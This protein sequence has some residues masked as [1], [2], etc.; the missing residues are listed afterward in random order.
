MRM[1]RVKK[2]TGR[3]FFALVGDMVIVGIA[4]LAL[5]A[6]RGESDEFPLHL[7]VATRS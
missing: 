1:A 2:W 4:T 7:V 5:V 6:A 3:F